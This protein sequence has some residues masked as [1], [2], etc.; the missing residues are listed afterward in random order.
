VINQ[1]KNDVFLREK[2]L[3]SDQINAFYATFSEIVQ[4]FEMRDV[5]E[6]FDYVQQ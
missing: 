6:D 1:F 3:N 5:V 2:I 4:Q